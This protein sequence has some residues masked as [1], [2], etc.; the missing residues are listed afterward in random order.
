MWV[1][2]NYMPEGTET[3]ESLKP[4]TDDEKS[5][6][7][8]SMHLSKFADKYADGTDILYP[9]LRKWGVDTVVVIG[10]WTEDCITVRHE[11]LQPNSD[12]N[13]TQVR[14]RPEC[15]HRPAC[16]CPA[17]RRQ[18]PSKASTDTAST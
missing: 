4:I 7:I 13:P 3:M 12:L 16:L 17:C 14:G 1:D 2:T 15:S 8:K 6:S 18:R 9:M 10:A 11:T 5:L